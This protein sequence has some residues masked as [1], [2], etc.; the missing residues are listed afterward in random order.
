[1]IGRTLFF[2]KQF[3]NPEN[4]QDLLALV[5]LCGKQTST[6]KPKRAK[7]KL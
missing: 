2:M 1:M 7:R 3:T 4:Q 6:G 5:G